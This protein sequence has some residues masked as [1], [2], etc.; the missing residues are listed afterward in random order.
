MIRASELAGRAVIDIDA[1]EKIGTIDKLILD[2]DGTRVAGFVTSKGGG[3]PGN[4]EQA[5]LPSSAVHAIGPDAVT[6]QRS[7]VAPGDIERLESLPRGTEVI[8]RKVISEDGRYLGKVA[9]VL[10]ER[11]D[12]RILGYALSD[13]GGK[14]KRPYLPADSHL[15]TGKDLIVTS[16]SAM[17][18]EWEE[19]TTDATDARWRTE[20]DRQTPATEVSDVDLAARD[21]GPRMS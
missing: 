21:T 13:Y 7:A 15:R 4:R 18:Y 11:A 1:A 5:I 2:P 16:E 6:V 12:G 17:R 20:H 8:G 10:I 14:G 3:F 19:D 9:D